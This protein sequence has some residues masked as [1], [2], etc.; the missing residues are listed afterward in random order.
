MT[1]AIRRHTR[2]PRDDRQTLISRAAFSLEPATPAP[3]TAAPEY[4][5]YDKNDEKGCRVHVAL[6]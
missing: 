2:C 6:L 1:A 4:Q 5:Q 3:I